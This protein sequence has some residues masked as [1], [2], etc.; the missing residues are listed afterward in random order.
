M[1]KYILNKIKM[2]GVIQNTLM[3]VHDGELRI[4]KKGKV[5]KSK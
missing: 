2:I 4:T 3:R 5:K 1:I